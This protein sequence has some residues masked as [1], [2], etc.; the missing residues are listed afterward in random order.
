MVYWLIPL[1]AFL[2]LAALFVA[3][4]RRLQR[5]RTELQFAQDL[6][7]QQRPQLQEAFFQAAASSGK[8]RGLRWHECQWEAP[9]AWV[10]DRHTGQLLVLVGIT[11]A[12]EAIE[13]G[14]MEGLPAVGNLRNASAVFF[15]QDGRW[16][17]AGH[18]I[19]NLN[20]DEAVL[21]YG[22][23]YERVAVS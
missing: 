2:F 23:R 20:P 8:P 15:W 6:F 3:T 5:E 12:F 7:A 18:A 16:Q 13:G 19:F 1:V 17:T 22:Q 9:V 21:H 11:V 4:R 10:R 14:D